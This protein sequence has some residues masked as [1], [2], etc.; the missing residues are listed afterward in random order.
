MDGDFTTSLGN[1]CQ[2]SVALT[3]KKFFPDVPRE[4]PVFWFVPIDS[5]PVTGHHLGGVWLCVLC[6][7]PSGF[8]MDKISSMTMSLLYWGPQSLSQY[9]RCGLI[10]AEQRR[11]TSLDLLGAFLLV[12]PR[13]PSLAFLSK[14]TLLSHVQLGVQW[15]PQALFCQTALWPLSPQHVLMAPSGPGQSA[16]FQ[17]TSQSPHLTHTSISFSVRVSQEAVPKPH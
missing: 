7:I 2:C 10:R 17:S 4:P 16:G 15:D 11:I 8:E 9:S 1:P 6:T 14:G 13:I 5:G 3:G 12:Q